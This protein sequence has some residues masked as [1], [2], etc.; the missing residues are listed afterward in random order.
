MHSGNDRYDLGALYA[1]S[2]RSYIGLGIG[3]EQTR[4]DLKFVSGNTR[5]DAW[6]PRVD[7]GLAL[8]PW[9]ALGLRAEDLRF[10]G[11]NAVNLRA[12]NGTTQVTRDLDYHRRY[13]QMESIVRLTRATTRSATASAKPWR[14]PSATGKVSASCAQACSCRAPWRWMVGKAG[15]GVNRTCLRAH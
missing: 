4:V 8:R 6:G 1:P 9:L 15:S 3:L 12:A 2:T 14:N 11:D 7:A 5:L 10:S 13:L